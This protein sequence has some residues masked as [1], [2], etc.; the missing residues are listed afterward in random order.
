MDAY[1][2]ILQKYAIGGCQ[3]SILYATFSHFSTYF[4][5]PVQNSASWVCAL[6]TVSAAFCPK[7][8]N[9]KDFPSVKIP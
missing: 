3:R 2:Q 8:R 5:F 6:G 4:S 9:S 7:L 1:L